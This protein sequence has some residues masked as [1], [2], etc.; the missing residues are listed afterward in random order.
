[1]ED[2]LHIV[3]GNPSSYFF[4]RKPISIR[5]YLST[6]QLSV[7]WVFFLIATDTR[8]ETVFLLPSTK[9]Q[10]YVSVDHPILL[11]NGIQIFFSISYDR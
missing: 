9:S 8:C 5:F 10:L 7:R 11:I 4:F 6:A 3:D 1:M 2:L